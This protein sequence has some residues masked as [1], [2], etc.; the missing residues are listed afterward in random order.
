MNMPVGISK[1]PPIILSVSL[2]CGDG[3]GD[4]DIKC[5]FLSGAFSVLFLLFERPFF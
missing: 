3:N 5:R 1:A 2:R 4:G